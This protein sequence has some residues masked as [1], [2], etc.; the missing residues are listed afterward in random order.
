MIKKAEEGYKAENM[1]Q[2]PCCNLF[3]FTI[4]TSVSTYSFHN[5]IFSSY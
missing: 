3:F 4:R 5:D 1:T 2:V